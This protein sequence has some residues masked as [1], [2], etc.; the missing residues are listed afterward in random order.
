MK[1]NLLLILIPMIF[2]YSAISQTT[3]TFNYTGTEQTFIIPSCVTSITFD[4]IAASGGTGAPGCSSSQSAT[5]GLGGRVQG[6][7][8]VNGG[9]TLYIYVGGAGAD[10]NNTS[11]AGGFNGGGNAL[12]E[13][14]YTYYGG[15]GGGGASDIR[16]NG[17]TLNDRAVVAGGG[18]GAGQ[19]GCNCEG[20][21]GGSGGDVTGGAG[22]P[23]PVCVCNPAGQ[24]GTSAAGGLRGD[25]SCTCDATDGTFGIGGNSNSTSCGGPTGGAG[26]GGGWY[27]GGGGG[28]GPG[29]GGSSYTIPSAT[30]VVHTQ[31]YQ[32]GNGIITITYTGGSGPAVALGNDTAQCGGT[33]TLNA[34]FPGSTYLWSTAATTQTIAVS[35]T[36]TY[37]VTV[38]DINGCTG[39]DAIHVT[40]NPLPAVTYNETQNFACIN[41]APIILTPGIPSG[42]TYSGAAVAGNTFVPA[43]AGVGAHVITYTYTDVNNCENTD[44]STITVSLCTGITQSGA[45]DAMVIFPNPASNYLRIQNAEYGIEKIEIMNALGQVFNSAFYMRNSE[46]SVDVSSLNPGI[47]LLKVKSKE[48]DRVGRF[49]KQ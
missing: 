39:T 17:N 23:G 34:G 44:T 40:I 21:A 45:R 5:G 36:G 22:Q 31:G 25:W 28:L 26:G 42:G 43:T 32:T 9:D 20:L 6:T 37:T 11:A 29:G 14:Q 10:D 16:I 27:G 8:P 18:G 1:K 19:D 30:G 12:M 41:W 2:G 4:V 15:G 49:V 7:L 47:Y 46:L 3:Q 48:G 38:T 33:V 24:G 35:T 13:S